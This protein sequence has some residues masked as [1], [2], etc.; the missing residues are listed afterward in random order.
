MAK[1]KF[2]TSL[3]FPYLS[4]K[5]STNRKYFEF[6]AL[7]DTGYD[8]GV[9]VPPKLITNGEVSGWVVNCK[10]ADNSIVQVPAYLGLVRLGN[11][12]LN[13]ITVLIMG[14]EPIIGREVI[15]YFRIILDYGQK[16]VVEI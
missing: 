13:N 16:V 14:D 6:E 1:N 2:V 4:I 9:V 12:K 5:V 15:K 7:L 11:K 3:R 8:G 10:L